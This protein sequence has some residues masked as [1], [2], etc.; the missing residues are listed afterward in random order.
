MAKPLAIQQHRKAHR[1]SAPALPQTMATLVIV[2]LET[3][4]GFTARG[5][6]R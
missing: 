1:R 3:L 6:R 5:S 2:P 4:Q